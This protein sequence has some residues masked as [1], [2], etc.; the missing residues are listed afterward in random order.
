MHQSIFSKFKSNIV[1]KLPK[2]KRLCM[3]S[4]DFSPSVM[5]AQWRAHQAHSQ[6]NYNN[7][8]NNNIIP[9]ACPRSYDKPDEYGIYNSSCTFRS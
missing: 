2:V 7:N 3:H 4:R 1:I 8:N 9:R 6:S 5:I